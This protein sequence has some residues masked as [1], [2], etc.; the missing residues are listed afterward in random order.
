MFSYNVP[1]CKWLFSHQSLHTVGQLPDFIN[2]KYVLY[3]WIPPIH[4]YHLVIAGISF[5]LSFAG[6]ASITKQHHHLWQALTCHLHPDRTP[7]S[8]HSSVGHRIRWLPKSERWFLQES[9][10]YSQLGPDSGQYAKFFWEFGRNCN[11]HSW[12]L[13][14]SE[15][16]L[17]CYGYWTLGKSGDKDQPVSGVLSQFKADMKDS[18]TGARVGSKRK[19]KCV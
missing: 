1:K 12:W 2:I 7:P 19:Q 11:Y 10:T 17:Q 6:A 5:F 8:R 18:R 14:T 15:N 3:L 4:N 16:L 13:P 9:T